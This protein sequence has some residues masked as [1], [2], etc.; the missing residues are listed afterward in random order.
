[1]NKITALTLAVSIAASFVSINV[2]AAERAAAPVPVAGE[3]VDNGLGELPHYSK[4]ADPT[5]KNPTPAKASAKGDDKQ[6]QR[7][8]VQVSQ[9]K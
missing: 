9:A 7:Q 6:A 8:S 4:W 1:M 5:G 2:V 3:K